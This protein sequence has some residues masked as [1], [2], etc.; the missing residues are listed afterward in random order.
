MSSKDPLPEGW[1][2]RVDDIGRVFYVDHINRKT[3]WDRPTNMQATLLTKDQLSEATT[4]QSSI[5]NN[6]PLLKKK[7]SFFGNMLSRKD[8]GSS[9]AQT[10]IQVAM[11]SPVP[12]DAVSVSSKK[13]NG[14]QSNISEIE[15]SNYYIDNVELQDL[16][17][18]LTP[19]LKST[20][21]QNATSCFRCNSKFVPP[22]NTKN[23]CRCCGQSYC[24]K[25]IS[26]KINLNY[27]ATSSYIASTGRFLN[28]D[29][30]ELKEFEGIGKTCDYCYSH[31]VSGDFNSL[32][33]YFTLISTLPEEINNI[34]RIKASKGLLLSISHEKIWT[35]EDEQNSLYDSSLKYP[36]L[37]EFIGRIRG[38]DKLWKVLFPQIK[39]ETNHPHLRIYSIRIISRVISRTVG[40][41]C[42]KGFYSHDPI[43][44]LIKYLDDPD[45]SEPSAELLACCFQR[46]PQTNSKILED[47]N[48]ILNHLLETLKLASPSLQVHLLSIIYSI[49]KLQTTN[50]INIMKY[51]L[52]NNFLQIIATCL[53][54]DSENL[55]DISTHIVHVIVQRHNRNK[56][57]MDEP[58]NQLMQDLLSLNIIES[59]TYICCCPDVVNDSP[60]MIISMEIFSIAAGFINLHPSLAYRVTPSLSL[61]PD[62][63][64]KNKQI[65]FKQ[66]ASSVNGGIS[67]IEKAVDIIMDLSKQTLEDISNCKNYG[68]GCTP[69]SPYP[70]LEMVLKLLYTYID[71]SSNKNKLIEDNSNL[72]MALF[73]LIT[74]C[75][76]NLTRDKSIEILKLTIFTPQFSQQI[77]MYDHMELFLESLVV[78]IMD[79]RNKNI[80]NSALECLSLTLF[81]F[82]E[83]Y[84]QRKELECT[85]NDYG[86]SQI[87]PDG[88]ALLNDMKVFVRTLILN[89]INN[90]KLWDSLYRYL[91]FQEKTMFIARF[92][93][94]LASFKDVYILTCIQE[95]LQRLKVFDRL[96]YSL[97]DSDYAPEVREML[98]YAVG[99]LIG[100]A[101]FFQ[102]DEEVLMEKKVPARSNDTRKLLMQSQ[103]RAECIEGTTIKELNLE[104]I[105][106]GG[107]N[108][109]YRQA[110]TILKVETTWRDRVLF[111]VQDILIPIF[112]KASSG[113]AKTCV[114]ALRILQALLRFEVSFPLNLQDKLPYYNFITIIPLLSL[115]PLTLAL[116]VFYLLSKKSSI[117]V[118]D[119][120][121]CLWD[122]L[123]MY[124]PID[125]STHQ[126]N[127]DPD[128][129]QLQLDR[130]VGKEMQLKNSY[131]LLPT[132]VLTGKIV[133]VFFECSKNP[134][135]HELIRSK[136]LPYKYLILENHLNKRSIDSNYIFHSFFSLLNKLFFVDAKDKTNDLI[137]NKEF[138][139]IILEFINK[140]PT[141]SHLFLFDTNPRESSILAYDFTQLLDS[142]YKRE[143]S[144]DVNFIETTNIIIDIFV[145]FIKN[146]ENLFLFFNNEKYF[147]L[148]VFNLFIYVEGVSTTSSCHLY[149]NQ[150]NPKLGSFPIDLS[151]FNI[152]RSFDKLLRN[153]SSNWKKLF[154]TINTIWI[155]Q[156]YFQQNFNFFS[157]F[158]TLWLSSD[159]FTSYIAKHVI[160]RY[161]ENQ[162]NDLQFS[163]ENCSTSFISNDPFWSLL[164]STQSLYLLCDL[165]DDRNI[166][167]KGIYNSIEYS[168]EFYAIIDY[169]CISSMQLIFKNS[170]SSPPSPA[171]NGSKLTRSEIEN[172]LLTLCQTS[173]FLISKLQG[174]KYNAASDILTIVMALMKGEKPPENL[175]ESSNIQSSSSL[176]ISNNVLTQKSLV[177]D[178]PQSTLKKSTSNSSDLNSYE[179]ASSSTYTDFVEQKEIIKQITQKLRN[180]ENNSIQI[181]QELFLNC[182]PVKLNK[183]IDVM[184]DIYDR[185]VQKFNSLNQL[186]K[187]DPQFIANEER[188]SLDISICLID[189]LYLIQ[190][191]TML[192]LVKIENHTNSDYLLL[193]PTND[194]ARINIFSFY[195]FFKLTINYNKISTSFVSN[196]YCIP[197]VTSS[198]TFFIKILI[199]KLTANEANVAA[200]SPSLSQDEISS[201]PE[202]YSVWSLISIILL[203]GNL[204]CDA[205]C[206]GLLKGGHIAY[207][208]SLLCDMPPILS[209]IL[210][211]P[212]VL[213]FSSETLSAWNRALLNDEK[214]KTSP[215]TYRIKL[216][217]SNGFLI[218]ENM[219]LFELIISTL[220]MISSA[221][222]NVTGGV[223]TVNNILSA[224]LKDPFIIPIISALI[225]NDVSSLEKCI[226]LKQQIK[227]TESPIEY[228]QIDTSS[229]PLKST[230]T[231]PATP[232]KPKSLDTNS[233][234]TPDHH[235]L[236]PRNSLKQNTKSFENIKDFKNIHIINQTDDVYIIDWF[237]RKLALLSNLCRLRSGANSIAK[238]AK[239]LGAILDCISLH[240]SPIDNSTNQPSINLATKLCESNC[241]LLFLCVSFLQGLVSQL[242]LLDYPQQQPTDESAVAF[243]AQLQLLIP[244]LLDVILNL[245]L[246]SSD[247]LIID[248]SLRTIWL[249]APHRFAKARISQLGFV[250]RLTSLL[251]RLSD[252][253]YNLNPEDDIPPYVLLQSQCV[254]RIVSLLV[255]CFRSIEH[256]SYLSAIDGLL[257]AL[258]DLMVVAPRST[259]WFP[260]I[261]QATEALQLLIVHPTNASNFFTALQK[262]KGHAAEGS[263]ESQVLVDMLHSINQTLQPARRAPLRVD[264]YHTLTLPSLNKNQEN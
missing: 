105:K 147:N 66:H 73:H 154:N 238:N 103:R 96:L 148:L 60:L 223:A 149:N 59:I 146:E 252:R 67:A 56:S 30:N 63:S 2:E 51:L 171:S 189:L 241:E 175:G 144:E 6:A 142:R 53:K 260:A 122:L 166:S 5:T 197:I 127:N 177:N 246:T 124:C 262:T 48:S 107:N 7:S 85:V 141:P 102:W 196:P 87:T 112:N 77:V 143:I 136:F 227:S 86:E 207:F 225:I 46:D 84:E 71:K 176:D 199:E 145:E 214:M 62:K 32:L 47:N 123:E 180:S 211:V 116:D 28:E 76:H 254:E 237:N 209:K 9:K 64:Q 68:I 135:A 92:L 80:L 220:S 139:N 229:T 72:L 10:S 212:N 198:L 14:S 17:L 158:I 137:N 22:L 245:S 11:T 25:C 203:L 215:N 38:Y 257:E 61:S 231:L 206:L 129:N 184:S 195:N 41:E 224:I 248:E 174:L 249:L 228:S 185:C 4:H 247:L 24:K 130:N 153:S 106:K 110:T 40:T 161:L 90:E 193:P 251:C 133:H 261:L 150:I 183:L 50:S 31:Y 83:H 42:F 235:Y 138:M 210:H 16:C 34:V 178:E 242:H 113:T 194:L 37:H 165:M 232:L 219:T 43:T 74:F 132:E 58:M 97:S 114:A 173:G 191:L 250:Q 239:L 221:S 104:E 35:N 164:I 29:P 79:E 26:K 54:T 23:T 162:L 200:N 20:S 160:L 201:L 69:T 217:K 157:F 182:L 65:V 218:Y 134:K 186:N 95:N 181:T 128:L 55:Q 126:I 52:E 192:N 131:S 1:E 263:L 108:E 121:E 155:P 13:S 179:L 117:C 230:L 98:L 244:K 187:S 256:L 216:E 190:T 39:T 259:I 70:V 82:I 140:I 170:S 125:Y 75:P 119:G 188:D 57:L 172:T 169:L 3:Q 205:I 258:L 243:R 204:N 94:I 44:F 19:L 89:I 233:T 21:N 163:I 167:I 88:I 99:S 81:Y 101:P 12:H 226:A 255:M 18:S 234:S 156:N 109:E 36:A 222:V 151:N 202:L 78:S 159:Q 118:E 45:L 100:C 240:S 213:S 168:S 27:S 93:H 115:P 152:F 8:S 264:T 236:S 49:L 33:K 253:S 208:T 120:F 15:P 91:D 111:K